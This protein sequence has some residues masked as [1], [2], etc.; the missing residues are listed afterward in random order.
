MKVIKCQNPT[1]LGKTISYH[2]EFCGKLAIADCYDDEFNGE[3]YRENL[4]RETPD[5]ILVSARKSIHLESKNTEEELT[6]AAVHLRN[7]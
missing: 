4:R 2:N 7:R 5:D 1:Y 6:A 3:K